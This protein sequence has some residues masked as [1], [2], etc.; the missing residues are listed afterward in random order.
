MTRWPSAPL[1][2]LVRFKSGGTPSKANPSYWDGD[3]P[4]LSA[5]DLKSFWLN[6]S[7]DHITDR[8]VKAGARLVPSGSVLVLI[9]GMTLLKDVPVG[10]TRCPVAFNQD[11]KGLLPDEERLLPE[12]LGYY[13]LAKKEVL[14]SLVTQ[15]GHGTGRLSVDA[16]AELEVPL[17]PLPEQ[18]K[19]AAILGAWDRALEKLQALVGAKTERLGALRQQLLTGTRRFPEF[20]NEHWRHVRLAEV[21]EN[22]SERNDGQFDNDRLYAVTKAEGIVPMRE[23]VMGKSHERCKIVAP[24]WFAYNPMR[25]NIGSISRWQGKQPIMV[26]AD[27]VVFRCS[28][29][30]LKPDFLDHVRRS[31]GW[32]SF[33]KSSGNGSVRVRIYFDDLGRF[34]FPLPSL[35][36]Q[37]SIVEVLNACDREISLLRAE[38]DALKQQKRGLMQKLLTG[39]IRVKSP[40][41]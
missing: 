35:Q 39:E 38:L 9:R 19:I 36:E 23:R 2:E 10:V 15:A 32:N 33:V 34:T 21:A 37:Q 22:V 20:R 29:K 7:Q 28:E 40:A 8:A 16:L 17:P 30:Q 4:W 24:E 5:K 41:R 13:L 3:V 1:A 18:Q 11:V 27:Y 31:A 25:L 12:F 26:S 6:D 14:R